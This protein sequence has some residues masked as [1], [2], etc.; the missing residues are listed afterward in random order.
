MESY[1]LKF[2]AEN[3]QPSAHHHA[4]KAADVSEALIFARRHAPGLDLELWDS[5]KRLCT[6]KPSRLNAATTAMD[7]VDMQVG[8]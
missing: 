6:L 7:D 4:F 3:G 1:Y 2:L 8:S 5:D